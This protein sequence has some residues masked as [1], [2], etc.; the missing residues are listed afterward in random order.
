MMGKVKWQRRQRIE[1]FEVSYFN[2][3]L[4][5]WQPPV[6]INTIQIAESGPAKTFSSTQPKTKRQK[7]FKFQTPPFPLPLFNF[8]QF[9]LLKLLCQINFLSQKMFEI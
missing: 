4:C 8:V 1:E 2:P 7:L 6:S 5:K 3:T 9:N